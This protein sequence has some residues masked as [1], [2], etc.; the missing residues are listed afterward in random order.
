MQI[1]YMQSPSAAVIALSAMREIPSP[2]GGFRSPFGP[3]SGGVSYAVLGFD[4]DLVLDFVR[5]VY[6]EKEA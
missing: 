4:P 1:A 5:E 3:V 6:K 2:L